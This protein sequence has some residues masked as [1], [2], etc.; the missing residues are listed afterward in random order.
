MFVGSLHLQALDQAKNVSFP[1]WVLY[2]TAT[3]SSLVTFGRY[4][5]DLS[6]N[7][8]IAGGQFPCVVLSHGRGSSP[9][10][11]RS[12]AFHLAQNGFVVALPEHHGNNRNNNELDGTLANLEMRPR[13]LSLAID[14]LL[15]APQLRE[16]LQQENVAV[17][18]HSIGGYGALA[19]A[20][21]QP[22]I[23][24]NQKIGVTPDPRIGALVLMAPVTGYFTPPDSL[25][26]VEGP[27][28]LYSAENDMWSPRWQAQLVLDYLPGKVMLKVVEK[29]G[30]YSFLSPFP[31]EMKSPHFP[32]SIDPQ[33]FDREEFHRK[34][35]QEILSFLLGSGV[36]KKHA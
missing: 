28:L 23:G 9:L 21:G 36:D 6:R 25:Q 10:V 27:I 20:G 18:G 33:G 13:H 19:A 16:F 30:H 26:H 17:I 3:P 34:L 15:S 14:T 24:I 12:M 11:Y 1:V 8:P 4:Q 29:A 35:N 2:P 32:P 22:W 7:A 31:E 5:M